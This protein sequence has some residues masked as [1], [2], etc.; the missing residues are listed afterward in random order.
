VRTPK[1]ASVVFVANARLPTEKAHGQ[2]IV[3]LCEAFAQLGAS[4]E[5]WHPRRRQA[6]ASLA[7]QT[8]FE[9]YGVD[10][11]YVVRQL[12][13]LDVLRLETCVPGPVFA[14]LFVCHE[15]LWGLYASRL[16][17]RRPAD[18]YVTRN[19]M[20]AW[21][22]ARSGLPTVL[23][24][25][26]AL[27]RG[28]KSRVLRGL[29]A[30]PSMRAFV[31]LTEGN[32][33]RLI[34]SGISADRI[35]KA[36]SAVDVRQYENLPS[37]E[38][39]RSLHGLPADRLIVGYIGRFEAV[40]QEKGIDFLIRSFAVMKRRMPAP[41]LLLCAGGP[42]HRVP[43]YLKVA[44]DVGLGPDDVKFVDHVAA[45]SV[46]T[47]IGSLDVATAPS[48]P[49]A[50]FA[51]LTSPLKLQEYAAAG[52]RIVTTDLPANREA[53]NGVGG[54]AFATYGDPEAMAGE[55]EA[56]LNRGRTGRVQ[57]SLVDF[58]HTYLNRAQVFLDAAAMP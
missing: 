26:T 42:M 46:P 48:P 44:R 57:R 21:A 20:V 15:A 45:R 30:L 34:Q 47:L 17:A 11:S 39:C 53:L 23:D 4:V 2:A 36:P 1:V 51:H 35:V 8:V 32:R 18:L 6:D 49:T 56:A 29:A 50:F 37:R 22:L 16:A 19:V 3:K 25:H 12:P 40:G 38:E 14:R 5:L 31:A 9:Y 24:V 58:P 41:A 27:S 52:V 28:L 55:L 54:V 13:N 33:Q 7:R 10:P 43:H